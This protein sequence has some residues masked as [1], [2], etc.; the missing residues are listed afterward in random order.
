MYIQIQHTTYLHVILHI[1]NHLTC[2][3]YYN[4]QV[5]DKSHVE[6]RSLRTGT[7]V[8][9]SLNGVKKCTKRK[10]ST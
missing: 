8:N 2:N 1:T 5:C 9:M 3:Q 7:K 4:I 6:M 10:N